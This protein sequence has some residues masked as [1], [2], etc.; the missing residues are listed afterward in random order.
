MRSHIKPHPTKYQ[1][2]TTENKDSSD[3][4]NLEQ[5]MSWNTKPTS[6]LQESVKSAPLVR[7]LQAT[8]YIGE[9]GDKINLLNHVQPKDTMQLE[10]STINILNKQT[11]SIAINTGQEEEKNNK[12]AY[13]ADQEEEKNNKVAYN[14]DQ[15]EEKNNKDLMRTSTF[16]TATVSR[17]MFLKHSDRNSP[18]KL[19]SSKQNSRSSPKKEEKRRGNASEGSCE[20][21]VQRDSPQKLDSVV[22][23]DSKHYT[24]ESS[25]A[26]IVPD[27]CRKISTTTSGK[28]E[29]VEKV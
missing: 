8:V 19:F 21:C 23:F 12:V 4:Q 10:L 27:E 5:D 29:N 15:E 7:N 20:V 22:H 17:K 18:S 6:F 26:W 13:N 2:I 24:F 11:D 25:A 3:T 28:I 14:S 9:R 1:A 16:E